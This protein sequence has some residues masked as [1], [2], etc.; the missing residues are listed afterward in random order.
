MLVISHSLT[1]KLRNNNN[2]NI[3]ISCQ[4]YDAK[5]AHLFLTHD[6]PTGSARALCA[7]VDVNLVLERLD[8][9]MVRAGEWLTVVGYVEHK[10][11]LDNV[12]AGLGAAVA[13]NGSAWDD[14][15][16]VVVRALMVWKSGP[17]DIGLYES[18]V[19]R[20]D[21][22][23]EGHGLGNGPRRCGR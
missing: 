17:L 21:R 9:E 13:G 1:H 3:I 2:N 23:V 10:A 16:K 6:F 20:M 18:Q 5:R 12:A 8:Y 15:V 22:T 11:M 19:V 7:V 4:A 14:M